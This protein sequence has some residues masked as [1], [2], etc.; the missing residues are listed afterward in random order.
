MKK[1]APESDLRAMVAA[2]PGRQAKGSEVKLTILG[3]DPKT[4]FTGGLGDGTELFASI[5]ITSGQQGPL[6]VGAIELVDLNDPTAEAQQLYALTSDCF[7]DTKPFPTCHLTGE[8]WRGTPLRLERINDDLLDFEHKYSFNLRYSQRGASV[9]LDELSEATA[10]NGIG[11]SFSVGAS[12]STAVTPAGRPTGSTTSLSS[13]SPSSE[14]DKPADWTIATGASTSTPTSTP[15]VAKPTDNSE[16]VASGGNGLST[17]AKAGIGAGVAAAVLIVIALVVA[18]WVRRSRRASSRNGRSGGMGEKESVLAAA[19][20]GGAE[21]RDAD[22]A[23]SGVVGGSPVTR[24]PVGVPATSEAALA[25]AVSPASTTVGVAGGQTRGAGGEGQQSMLNA[26]ERER[27][28]EE[29][30]RLDE[31]I[32]EAE[33]RRLG[34]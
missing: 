27:W 11:G 21:Y 16:V 6:Y 23:G 33:R 15:I 5:T 24:K 4:P 32:A 26:E 2:L 12:A 25:D 8:D 31:D 28:E 14:P 30:R 7:V 29:E 10:D 17:G 9:P 13:L 34:A 3:N 20:P 18:W 22:E 19:A 1:R